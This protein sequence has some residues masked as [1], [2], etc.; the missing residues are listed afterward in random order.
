[1]EFP[2]YANGLYLSSV[3]DGIAVY[4]RPDLTGSWS[5]EAQIKNDKVICTYCLNEGLIGRELKEMTEEEFISN[6]GNLPLE[7]LLRNYE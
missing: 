6:N 1:M 4:R 3:N 5:L 2:K 7:V